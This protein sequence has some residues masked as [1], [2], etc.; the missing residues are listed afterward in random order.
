M[1]RFVRRVV[2]FWVAGVVIG[3]FLPGPWKLAIGTRPFM[4]AHPLDP[5]HRVLH[6]VTFGVTAVLFMLLRDRVQ[7]RARAAVA[8]LLL[9]CAI[10]VLQFVTGLASVFEWW[11]LRDDLCG[12]AVAFVA[13][14]VVRV[15][16]ERVA[17]GVGR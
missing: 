4:K 11:D 12:V 10:E 14:E 5:R 17:G 13:V 3:S 15:W 9:G 7:D 1:K 2:P 6:F 16:R 8:A